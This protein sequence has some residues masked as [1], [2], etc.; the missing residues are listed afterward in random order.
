MFCM[1][2]SMKDILDKYKDA[3]KFSLTGVYVDIK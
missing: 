3:N 2:L 1:V